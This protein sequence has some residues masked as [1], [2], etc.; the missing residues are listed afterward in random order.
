MTKQ[1]NSSRLA[2]DIALRF[3]T[4][5]TKRLKLNVRKLWKLIP[6]FVEVT[7]EKLMGEAFFSFILNRVKTGNQE[8]I[9]IIFDERQTFQDR[10]E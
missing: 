3:Y 4:S 2:L 8:V 10:P 1:I 6:T 7:G 5:V 9:G